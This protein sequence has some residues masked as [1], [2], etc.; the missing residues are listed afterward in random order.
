MNDGQEHFSAIRA[1]CIGSLLLVVG[2]VWIV[3][4][5]LLLN[6]GS[7]TSSSPPVGAVG[8]FVALLSI[9]LLLQWLRVRLS[10][11]RKELLVIYCM[12]V[13]FFPLASQGLWHRFVGILID[14][15]TFDS[16]PAHVPG[17]MIPQGVEL[18]TNGQFTQGLENWQGQATAH[19]YQHRDTTLPA[20]LL[21]NTGDEEIRELIQS[22]PRRA[23]DGSDRFVPGQKFFLAIDV[24]R[25]G[26]TS[27]SWFSGA[28]GVDGK[29]WED[30]G[31]PQSRDSPAD[32]VDGTGLAKIRRSAIEIPFGV[33]DNLWL[34]LRLA[35]PG[36]VEVAKVSLYSNEPIYRFVEGSTE[37][38]AAD[39]GRMPRDDTARLHYRP[40]STWQSW[41]YDVRG[42]IPWAAWAKPLASWALL[43][44]AMFGAMFALA[45]LVFRQWSDRE[46]LTFPLTAI[47]L[48][49]TAP[50][51]TRRGLLPK[52]LRTRAL[53]FGVATAVAV[54][55]LNGMSFYNS[56]IPGIPL[57]IDLAP[58]FSS[59]PW[60]ALL[61]D[62][63]GF[64]LRIVLLAV[65]VAFFM[66]LQLAFSL[67]LFYL[68]C[69]LFLIV[70]YYQGRMGQP[71]WPGG[72]SYGP[73]LWQ[74]QS[75]GAA[76]G[77]VL[78]ALWLGRRHLLDVCRK[79]FRNDS[80]VDDSQEPMPYRLAVVILV[81]SMA[82]AGVWGVVAGAGWWFGIW[83]MALM[84]VFAVMAS[85]VRAE[86]AAPN[87]WLVPAAPIVLLM[88][89]GG[90]V[91]FGVLPMTYFLL[92]GNFMCA[93]YFLMTMPAIMETFQIAKVAGIRR[94]V[95]GLVMVV[96]FV[97]A[98][99]AGGYAL[100]NW[101]YARGV[102]TMRGGLSEQDDFSSV[103][104][105]WR[106]EQ[107]SNM[108]RRFN[109]RAQRDAGVELS[110][111]DQ[112]ILGELEQMPLIQ[113]IARVV[114][115]S[116]AF[117]CLLAAA[118]LTFLSFP[119]HPLG[120][121]LATTP[122]MAYAWAS[123]LLAWLIR[124]AGLRL[125]GA[126]AIRNIL[127]PYMLGLILGSVLALLIW[128]AVGIFKISH[129]YTGQ[130]F[131]TW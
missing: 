112:H 108:V 55:S 104:F 114:P 29:R 131:V 99:S 62:G 23:A 85:R 39:A 45:A 41:L 14:V 126:R 76:I 81:L 121:V 95:I 60:S 110:E 19:Q 125:G 75:I 48:L 105:R 72:P 31:V 18:I 69:K 79:A 77:I 64:R 4:Q 24:K 20:A 109:L 93:G 35:G 8:L 80:R 103:L 102:S 65:G 10:L 129:G 37:I 94:R 92:M 96:G 46:K 90:L 22:I 7:L 49:L 47:P 5:E 57:N 74:F 87:M 40:K 53:W 3:V 51:E 61:A 15:R 100:L 83:S 130:I 13:T 106:A 34:R 127:Q 122:L 107:G 63:T 32:T 66:D 43:W 124:F 123:I 119:L 70:P 17:H 89:M 33:D 71:A 73:T 58:L 78:V 56:N 118:R 117:T 88:S 54:Y 101:G 36:R 28:M 21:A 38:D 120:Y 26:F 115:Y 12:L 111:D 25:S 27:R 52:V 42:Y 50:D 2:A 116:A 30:L 11:G 6:A 128:D 68:L 82:L 86:C 91:T 97:V 98:V 1:V 44:I 67:W 16:Y 113:P 84:L 59:S 9:V